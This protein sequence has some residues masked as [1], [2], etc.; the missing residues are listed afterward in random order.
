MSTK[1][2]FSK[3]KLTFEGVHTIYIFATTF[4]GTASK[5]NGKATNEYFFPYI[6]IS[7]KRKLRKNTKH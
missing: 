2:R 4:E 3:D 6:S 5:I 7:I 1:T